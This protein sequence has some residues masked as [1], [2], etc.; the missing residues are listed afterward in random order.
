MV[1]RREALLVKIV[2]DACDV[3]LRAGL[4]AAHG[5][6]KLV[7][8]QVAQ[9]QGLRGE[10]GGLDGE[11]APCARR[12][13]DGAARLDILRRDGASVLGARVAEKRAGPGEPAR[14]LRDGLFGVQARLREAQDLER[15]CGVEGPDGP[16]DDDEVFGAVFEEVGGALHERA[17]VAAPIYLFLQAP[18][19]F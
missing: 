19:P 8:G 14:Q 15:P 7:A 4:E 17:A 11:M 13:Q 12:G 1:V 6:P 5:N 3:A 10:S 18:G 16:L 9:A 2:G